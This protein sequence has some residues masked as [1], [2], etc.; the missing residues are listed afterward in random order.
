[1]KEG[2]KEFQGT[3]STVGDKGK[4]I[5][6]RSLPSKSVL[7]IIHKFVSI[8]ISENILFANGFYKSA[9]DWQSE[10]GL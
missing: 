1:M 6:S 4:N 9:G 2:T 8:K 3:A 5:R 10:N 7:P